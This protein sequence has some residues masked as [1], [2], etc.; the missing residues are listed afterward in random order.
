MINFDDYTNENIIEHNSK[1]PYIPDHSY[2]ILIIGSSGSGKTNA[3]DLIKNQLDID[4]IYLYAKDPYE[5][6]YQYLIKKRE[7]V[8][9]D[10]FDDPKAFIEYSND[11]QDVY[12]NI[13]DYNLEKERKILIVIENI[14]DM[15]ADI[16]NNKKLN[17]IVTELFIRGRKLNISIVFIMQSYFKVPKDVRLNLTHFFIMKILN[18]RELQQIALNHS[19]DIDF[20]DFMKIYKKCTKE[21]YSFLVND[22]TL[23]LVNI[24]IEIMTIDDQ[25]KDE[26]LQYD[27]NREAAKISALSSGKFNKYEYL[28]GEEILPSNK[29]QIIEQTKFTYSP[30]GKAFEKETKTIEDQGKKQ[31]E[32]LENLK[33]NERTRDKA[34]PIEYNNYFINKL[35]KIQKSIEPVDFDNLIYYYEGSNEPINFSEYNGM[36]NIFK[37]IHSG[38]KL[39]EDI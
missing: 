31:T 13:E 14:D 4:K 38:D 11:M 2:R 17:P 28:T 1:W 5:A 10:H 24:I 33:L 19:S 37:S 25:I 29:Q 8:G 26:K 3:L 32:A 22:T 23:F 39:L 36:M 15:I 27:I 7:K 6:K 20:K 9:L 21:P 12:K 16:I 18:K 34:K 30:L 35:A